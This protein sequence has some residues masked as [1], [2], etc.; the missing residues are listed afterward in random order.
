M[1]EHYDV[2]IVGGGMV[3]ATLGCALGGSPLRVAVLEDAPPAAFEPGQPHDLRVSAI[4]IASASIFLA[5][6]NLPMVAS[7]RLRVRAQ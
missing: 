1:N 6:D 3:G 4:S 2:V 7:W 5:T